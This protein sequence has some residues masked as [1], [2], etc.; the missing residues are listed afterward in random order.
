MRVRRHCKCKLDQ[1]TNI[2]SFKDGS[3]RYSFETYLAI[4]TEKLWNILSC[5]EK[6]NK[7]L[8]SPQCRRVALHFINKYLKLQLTDIASEILLI[9]AL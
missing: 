8:I 1:Q 7:L 4:N 5:F 6:N 2:P 3:M 9:F